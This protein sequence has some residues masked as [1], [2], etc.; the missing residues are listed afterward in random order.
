MPVT[1]LTAGPMASVARL[2]RSSM[3]NVLLQDYMYSARA[4]GVPEFSVIVKHGLR[5]ALVPVI[6]IIGL[7]VGRLVGGTVIVANTLAD[8]SYA[9]LVNDVPLAVRVH[10]I[11]S[12]GDGEQRS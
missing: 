9:V 4:R 11:R 12:T 3:L 8:I 5:N 6:T 7:Q 10:S 1:A 2:T